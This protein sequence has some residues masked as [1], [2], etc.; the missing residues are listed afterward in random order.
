MKLDLRLFLFAALFLLKSATTTAQNAPF[1][2][3]LEALDIP[4]LGGVQSFAYGQYDGKWLIIGGR[5]DGLHRRQ[6]FA[7]FDV[8]GHNNQLLVIDPQTLQKWSA[9]LASLPVGIREQLSATN[10]QFYQEGSYLYLIGGYGYSATAADHVTY[11]QLTAVQV[12]EVI[13]AIVNGQP[14]E[15]YFRQ[16]SDPVFTVTGGYLSKINHTYYLTGGQKFMGRYNPMGPTHGPGFVQEYTEQVRR[17]NLQDDGTLI[18]VQHLQAFTDSSVLH[19]RDLN[20][21]A[22]ILPD[23]RESI[24]AF[25][26]VFQKTVDFPYLNCVHIDSSGY[27]IQPDFNQYYNHYHCAVL[28]AYAAGS[29]EMHTVFFGG[30]AQFY[31]SLGVMVQDNNAPF[32]RTIARVTRKADGTMTEYKL[33]V[34]MPSLL[35]AGSAFL[36]VESLPHYANKVLQLD[37]ISADTTMVGYIFGGIS[38]TAPNIFWVNNGTQSSASSRIFKVFL[39][40]NATTGAHQLNDQSRGY[41]QM[42]I[43]P[44]PGNGIFSVKFNLLRPEAQVILTITDAKGQTIK[45]EILEHLAAG[46]HVI[47]RQFPQITVGNTYFVTIQSSDQRATLKTLVQD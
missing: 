32:V 29:N 30:I 14:M 31:D 27:S 39:V 4:T 26:G 17:F 9:P 7:S 42:K 36:P 21:V 46:E 43:F 10:I 38:S 5:L 20:V 23:G 3:Y 47:S 6:P 28:P 12:P 40:K 44:N 25:S 34:E 11:D 41:L 2:I 18:T 33:P 1:D 45:K 16:I 22:Q 15:T 8:A 13:H 35:G 37:E 19:R 24:T